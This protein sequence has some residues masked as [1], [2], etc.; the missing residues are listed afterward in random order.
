MGQALDVFIQ[1][2]KHAKRHNFGDFAFNGLA[3]LVFFYRFQPRVFLELF[4]GKR[5]AAF[6]YRNNFGLYFLAY[7]N[8]VARVFYPLPGQFAKYAPSLPFRQILQRR[9]NPLRP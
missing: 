5:Y 9:Q 1:F 7:L 6:V 3:D 2:H 4:Y 8:Y